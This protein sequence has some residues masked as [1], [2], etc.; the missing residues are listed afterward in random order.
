MAANDFVP[1]GLCEPEGMSGFN[2]ILVIKPK[3]SL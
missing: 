3:G 2:P 1:V